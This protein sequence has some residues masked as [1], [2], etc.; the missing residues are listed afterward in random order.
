[1]PSQLYSS[2][3]EVASAQTVDSNTLKLKPKSSAKQV[4]SSPAYN[5]YDAV[6]PKVQK[7]INISRNGSSNSSIQPK[8]TAKVL[9]PRPTR[10]KYRLLDEESD[11]L[12]IFLLTIVFLIT[13]FAYPRSTAG[14]EPKVSLQSVFY[15]G[16]VTAVA[17]GLGALPFYIISEPNKYWM[18]ISNG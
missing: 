16:W 14:E 10:F 15:H 18:G 7:M 6:Q 13:I 12:G 3:I 8:P 9:I 2:S 17:T 4:I 11:Y 1:M 5:R